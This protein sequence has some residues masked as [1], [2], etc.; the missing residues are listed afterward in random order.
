MAAEIEVRAARVGEGRLLELSRS[1]VLA[2]WLSR[3]IELR[4]LSFVFG[5]P[6]SQAG[7]TLRV[8][9]LV[10][11]R[12]ECSIEADAKLL[13]GLRLGGSSPERLLRELV[14]P[15]P[16]FGAFVSD[17]K[18]FVLRLLDGD[19]ARPAAPEY[20]GVHRL[21]VEVDA[22]GERASFDAGVA[23]DSGFTVDV[24]L[25]V[26]AA[27]QGEGGAVSLVC[28][29]GERTELRV[30][31]DSFFEDA[32]GRSFVWVASEGEFSGWLVREPNTRAFRPAP[33]GQPSLRVS[34][35]RCLSPMPLPPP[36]PPPRSDSAGAESTLASLRVRYAHALRD[37]AAA[38]RRLEADDEAEW[39]APFREEV[40]QP[41]QPPQPQQQQQQQQ[42][43][44]APAR[45][46]EKLQQC[47][48]LYR[49]GKYVEA[50]NAAEEALRENPFSAQALSARAHAEMRLD[51]F[52]DAVAD[53]TEALRQDANFAPAYRA[54]AEAYC[55]MGRLVEA[56][57]DASEA[58]RLAPSDAR[59]L[60]IR[61]EAFLQRGDK[62]RARRD[63]EALLRIAPRN[64]WVQERLARLRE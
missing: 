49:E 59:A 64:A 48:E 32:E 5:V 62:Q 63:F 16:E 39:L 55:R 1:E 24:G 17:L 46:S 22:F 47:A 8:R 37:V 57:R 44:A 20:R 33:P 26:S 58:L 7:R 9:D 18:A 41:P 31:A 3:E 54:R 43:R 25:R 14:E 30:P 15:E 23:N 28:E 60:A 52:V 34:S 42:Q 61:A 40:Q 36:P 29:S 4:V 10:Q 6:D 50:L 21:R 13:Q 35:L 19:E 45:E 11:F 56:V 12:L 53:A 38:V 2:L 27:H 51:A